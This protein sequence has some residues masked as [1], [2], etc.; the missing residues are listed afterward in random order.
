MASSAV[1]EEVD[2][3]IVSASRTAQPAIRV[4][5]SVSVIDREKIEERRPVF[6]TDLLQD[7]P[8]I[9]V[10]RA[11]GFGGQT[12]VRVRGSEANHVL[13][14]IDG[15]QANDLTASDEFAFEQLTSWDIE[16]IEVVRGPQ[17]AL[18]GSD[19]MAG[20]INITTRR[21][22][23][24]RQIGAFAEVGSFGTSF[25]GAHL[26]SNFERGTV[27]FSVSA[28][29]TD[30]ENIS[31]TGSEE[32]GYDNVT[33]S[34]SGTL[35][36]SDDLRLSM[37]GRYSDGT[38]EFDEIGFATSLPEDAPLKTDLQL[39]YFRTAAD[40]ALLNKRWNHKLQFTYSGSDRDNKDDRP[41]LEPVDYESDRYGFYYQT[42]YDFAGTP[43]ANRLTLAVDHERDDYEQRG[44][45]IF[46][47]DPN[48]NQ[49]IDNTGFVAEYLLQPL[50]SLNLSAS[51][52]YDDN[53]DFDNETTWRLSGSWR[54]DRTQTRLHASAGKG[55][56]AP[57]FIE[58]F[59]FFRNDPDFVGNPDLKPEESVGFDVGITQGF[60]EGKAQVDLTYFTDRV[61]D[62]INGFVFD[63]GSEAFTA[64]NQNGTSR[65]QGV[66]IELQADLPAN[67]DARASYTY[68]NSKEPD[69]TGGN[70]REVRRPEHMAALNLNYKFLSDRARVNLNVSYTGEQDDDF[71]PPPS[72]ARQTVQLDDYTLVNLV[73]SYE[74]SEVFSV[75]ARAENLFDENYE[76][77]L[78]YQALG[79]GYYAGVRIRLR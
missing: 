14:F 44:D 35:Q 51:V 46:G 39:F 36:A 22:Q 69:A 3:L 27:D 4:G 18:W 26:G 53:S 40:L 65:R 42:S 79:D 45:L 19:A 2:N 73:A 48:Q 55:Q 60:F 50:D 58:R 24:A 72:F 52:R 77:L 13:V 32:D 1:G 17:S 6:V 37:S 15:V 66:E 71:F 28:F 49:N 76:N 21:S 75:Y 5:S 70:R 7:L 43:A 61:E 29:D 57:T 11:G 68:T 8:G 47:S 56:K 20:V 12:Q 25:Y 16:R 54:L 59:G 33:A 10:S 30:G 23:D 9:A 34:L 38:S 67:F 64:E 63:A 78:G 62:E 74:V 31:Q 41:G